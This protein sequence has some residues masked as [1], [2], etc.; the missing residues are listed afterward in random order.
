MPK[1]LAVHPNERIDVPD[2]DHAATIYTD[3]SLSFLKERFLIDR[4]SRVIDGFRV[5]VSDQTATPGQI[6]VYNGNAI[7]RSGVSIADED[8]ANSSITVTLSGSSQTFYVEVEFTE[9]FTDTDSR[10]FW[11]PTYDNGVGVPTG[12]EVDLS[13]A[14]RSTPTWKVVY[15]ISTTGFD[16]TTNPNSTRVPLVKLTTNGSN[17]ITG[18]VNTLLSQVVAASVIE[19][20]T[21]AGSTKLR[22][23]DSRF[24]PDTGTVSLDAG[25][26]NPETSLTLV[27]NDRENGIL[28]INPATVYSHSA[29]A[30]VKVTGV[31]GRLIKENVDP[32]ATAMDTASPNHVVDQTRRFFQG[33]EIRGG[34]LA[35]S[36]ETT[37]GRDDLNLRSVKDYVDFVAGQIREM[38]FG[39]PRTEITSISPPSSF[40]SRP[41]YFDN[42][43]SITGARTASITIG[44]G[45][46]TFGDYNGST[47][48][49]FTAAIA[50]LPSGGRIYVK[51]GTYTFTSSVAIPT[52]ITIIGDSKDDVILV[53]NVAASY[54]FSVNNA[55]VG[56]ESLTFQSGT[57]GTDCLSITNGTVHAASALFTGVAFSNG[58][59]N[60]RDGLVSE[61]LH[62]TQISGRI[63]N[64]VLSGSFTTVGTFVQFEIDGC[65]IATDPGF[66]NFTSGTTYSFMVKNSF[67]LSSQFS[68]TPMFLWDAGST[69]LNVVVDSCLLQNSVLDC[70]FQSKPGIFKLSGAGNLT[71]ANSYVM[72][73]GQNTAAGRE[74]VGLRMETNAAN[75]NVAISN[76]KFINYATYTTGIYTFGDQNNKISIS[77]CDFY[78]NVGIQ[79]YGSAATISVANS[80]FY[81]TQTTDWYGFKA[82]Y[83]AGTDITRVQMTG[84]TFR[85]NTASTAIQ[86]GFYN[87]SG[88]AANLTNCKFSNLQYSSGV[89][90][91]IYFNVSSATI[92]PVELVVDGCSFYDCYGSTTSALI[93]FLNTSGYVRVTGNTFSSCKG[94][95]AIFVSS[96][97][98]SDV[99]N[100]KVYNFSNGS[101][102]TE[103][104]YVNTVS[105]SS[106]ISGNE[107]DTVTVLTS[108]LNLTGIR[109]DGLN[110]TTG[111]QVISNNI[112]SNVNTNATVSL[113][114]VY[115][116]NATAN[117]S[118]LSNKI[119]NLAN[120]SGLVYGIQV[121]TAG[122]DTI[123][124]SNTVKSL[125]TTAGDCMGVVVSANQTSLHIKGNNIT[126]LQT[127]GNTACGIYTSGTT[128]KNADISGNN[129]DT[130]TSTATVHG[131]IFTYLY[132]SKVSGNSF[133]NIDGTTTCNVTAIYSVSGGGDTI[134]IAGNR[135]YH[136]TIGTSGTACY[137]I[138]VDGSTGSTGVYKNINVSK[139]Y[140]SSAQVSGTT[141][142]PAAILI[143]KCSNTLVNDNNVVFA[144]GIGRGIY[145]DSCTGITV[146]N[147]TLYGDA[148]G[149]DLLSAIYFDITNVTS[150]TWN[151]LITN[152]SIYISAAKAT[153]SGIEINAFGTGKSLIGCNISGNTIV[154]TVAASSSLT[155]YLGIN[156]ILQSTSTCRGLNVVG[157]TIVDA[158]DG[159][160]GGVDFYGISI[161]GAA[162][163]Y[164]VYSC[165]IR[166]N[167]VR[168]QAVSSIARG[169]L[170]SYA[171]YGAIC[172]NV[173]NIADGQAEIAYLNCDG[174]IVQDNVLGSTGINDAGTFATTGSV[175]IGNAGGGPTIN[176]LT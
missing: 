120:S 175:N 72:V 55:T 22:V 143:K 26:T 24:F 102:N 78:T 11:D 86:Y 145:V 8:Q 89:N 147:N 41:R 168:S 74:A 65:S 119:F 10:G 111:S 156:I 138:R 23:F 17:Q 131:I 64:S 80:T 43:G 169:V 54:I 171:S 4:R 107:I 28:T 118:I 151:T 15:P 9:A 33:N 27:S 154:H 69:S 5:E 132:N 44:N 39:S 53:N 117:T 93:H 174:L 172:N 48:A 126:S 36:K 150:A 125:T 167:N 122:N 62:G 46:T 148:A 141:K 51:P 104:I 13:V 19:S 21:A 77:G 173:L 134:E 35:S 30:I 60:L 157:N 170:L 159:A 123:I 16:F 164:R 135:W 165:S 112:V 38:K 153:T 40:S 2:F 63:Y 130:L 116:I 70:S 32:N 82:T 103:V 88:V 81:N 108:I 57:G 79:D 121:G 47:N 14:T 42:A 101:A 31:T 37:A 92:K 96:A 144:G 139:N 25:G 110:L 66:V 58:T 29:G 50:A 49:V 95:N 3:E 87:A 71:I 137:F 45:T 160:L 59:F 97:F 105:S 99:S 124:S 106:T 140:L 84:C 90:Y 166:D 94:R 7:D 83:A 85:G 114:S 162:A 1:K 67:I 129:I 91:P 61:S 152:N 109:A 176:K 158:L 75:F 146:S 68:D 113:G 6:T 100:N 127:T 136:T 98:M 115:G 133:T 18:V 34:A 149:S 155:S 56:I 73:N 76:T 163:G 128:T 161:Q 52:N 20:D 12:K 142:F